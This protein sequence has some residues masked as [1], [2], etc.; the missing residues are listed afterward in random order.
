M[1][2]IWGESGAHGDALSSSSIGMGPLGSQAAH[3]ALPSRILA[4]FPVSDGAALALVMPRC[5]VLS[6]PHA[7]GTT[8]HTL[9]VHATGSF[10]P[11]E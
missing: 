7:L 3:H 2:E 1:A 10:M 5:C 4:T 11:Q 9:Q 8:P 6:G